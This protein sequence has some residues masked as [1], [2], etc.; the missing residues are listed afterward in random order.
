[1]P[2]PSSPRTIEV[3]NV[4]LWFG[5]LFALQY[6]RSGTAKSMVCMSHV[7]GGSEAEEIRLMLVGAFFFVVEVTFRG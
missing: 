5:T 4:K 7:D 6:I 2:G 1:M 3:T